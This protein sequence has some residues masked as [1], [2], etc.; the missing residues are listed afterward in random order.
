MTKSVKCCKCDK[1]TKV[2]NWF[3]F[4]FAQPMYEWTD[5]TRNVDRFCLCHKCT[6]KLA[7]FLDA[8]RGLASSYNLQ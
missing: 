3:N 8:S 1:K 5:S 7:I 2:Y 6:G 4:T